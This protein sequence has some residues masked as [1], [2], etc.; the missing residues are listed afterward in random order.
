[1][2]KN[3]HTSEIV[4]DEG[5][6]N[7]DSL[8]NSVINYALNA[9]AI[10]G[11]GSWL[12]LLLTSFR[13]GFSTGNEFFIHTL[14]YA[15]LIIITTFKKRLALNYKIF[16]LIAMIVMVTIA[17]FYGFGLF[18]NAKIFVAVFPI[19]LS[20]VLPFRKALIAMGFFI[21]LYAVFGYMYSNEIL[22]YNFD[23]TEYATKGSSWVIGIAIVVLASMGLLLVGHFFSNALVSNYITIGNQQEVLQEEEKK[24]RLLFE[25]S[26]DAIFIMKDYKY[27]NCNNKTYEL[28]GKTPEEILDKY[29]W[30]LSPEFQ[31]DGTYSKIKA[32][33]IF[34]KAMNG[35]AQVFD[36]QHQHKN[37]SLF[38]V[39]ISLNTIEFDNTKYVQVIMRD[40]SE[41]K[42]TEAELN[43]YRNQLE[44][45]VIEK[46]NDLQAANEELQAINDELMSKNNIIVEQK[47][48]IEQTLLYLRGYTKTTD[49]MLKKWLPLGCSPA[50]HCP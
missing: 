46:T 26:N 18:S 17:N 20:F 28:F 10:L 39:S 2:T 38:D 45:L 7:I 40:I 3:E 34:N 4:S 22:T 31:P 30:E 24:Y 8:R 19:F 1:M 21:L 11:T 41:Q 42:Q 49:S 25:S 23:L 43:I 33:E 14:A 36:W 35:L 16:A 27:Y 5:F 6:H 50:G 47:N 48:E 37:G 29:P 13:E 9:F 32:E 15:V 12:L 44:H